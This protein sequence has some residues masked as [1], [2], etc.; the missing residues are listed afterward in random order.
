MLVESGWF[1]LVE[2]NAYIWENDRK[3]CEAAVSEAYA[4]V[5]VESAISLVEVASEVF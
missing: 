5:G 1:W 2:E 4:L 3:A